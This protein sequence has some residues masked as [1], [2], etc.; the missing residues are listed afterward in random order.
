VAA[1]NT[2]NVNGTFNLLQAV[3]AHGRQLPD[4]RQQRFR[5]HPMSTHEVFGSL[6]ETGRCSETTPY[7]P[8]SPTSAS[9]AGGA[10]PRLQQLDAPPLAM[11]DSHDRWLTG[12]AGQQGQALR[13]LLEG[14][15]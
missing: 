8:R 12:A 5:A 1:P 2:S 14:V 6:G 10:H 7:D 3:R 11:R 9:K 15:A 4:E 13:Q